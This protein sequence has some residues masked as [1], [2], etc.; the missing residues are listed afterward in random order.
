MS[1]GVT[2]LGSK[3]TCALNFATSAFSIPASPSRARETLRTQVEPHNP[4]SLRVTSARTLAV[5]AGPESGAGAATLPVFD[6]CPL[7]GVHPN[8]PRANGMQTRR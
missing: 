1:L 6:D 3:R 5:S 7:P 4:V 2:C 8:G